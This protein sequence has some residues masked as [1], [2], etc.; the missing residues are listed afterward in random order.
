[1][2]DNIPFSLISDSVLKFRNQTVNSVNSFLPSFY[3]CILNCG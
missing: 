2:P 1:M 3:L